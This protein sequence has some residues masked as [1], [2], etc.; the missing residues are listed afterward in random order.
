ME[1]TVDGRR[2]SEEGSQ[3]PEDKGRK[4]D[5]LNFRIEMGDQGSGIKIEV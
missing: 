2:K 3:R 1:E 4:K 5:N